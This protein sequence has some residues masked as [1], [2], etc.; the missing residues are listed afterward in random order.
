MYFFAVSVR[1]PENLVE[2]IFYLWTPRLTPCALSNLG[3][4]FMVK[5]LQTSSFKNQYL[6]TK[7][8][9]RVFFGTE[10]P[11]KMKN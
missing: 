4:I 1:I 5:T 10:N 11:S 3:P 7:F 2:S 6:L 8:G 9:S